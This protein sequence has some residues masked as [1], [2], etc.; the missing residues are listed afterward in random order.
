MKERHFRSAIKAVSWRITGTID[1]ILISFLV[2]QEW[3]F[4]ISIG[5][6]EFLTKFVLFYFHERFWH[7]FKI[8]GKRGND[9]VL[10]SAFKSISWRIVGTIDTIVLS[11][12]VTGTIQHALSIGASELFTKII[13]YFVHERVWSRIKWG[14]SAPQNRTYSTT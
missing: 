1:T 8:I 13:L 2:T 14:C 6:S 3:K 10:K 9:H 5:F 12:I 7:T 4:A 11:Y